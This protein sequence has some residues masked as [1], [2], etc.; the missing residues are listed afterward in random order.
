MGAWQPM[1]S[2]VGSPLFAGS[3]AAARAVHLVWLRECDSTALLG[4]PAHRPAAAAAAGHTC[5]AACGAE[6]RKPAPVPP[7]VPGRRP[8][9]VA[10]GHTCTA[11]CILPPPN[12]S[13][14]PPSPVQQQ[15]YA[16]VPQRGE[17]DDVFG[18]R[19]VGKGVALGEPPH[20]RLQA[21][22]GHRLCRLRQAGG[23]G[24]AHKSSQTAAPAPARSRAFSTCTAC[25]N[26]QANNM[27]LHPQEDRSCN[28]LP[29]PVRLTDR[30]HQHPHN[31]AGNLAGATRKPIQEANTA[32][33]WHTP[34]SAS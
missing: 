22:A 11:A 28:C 6:L 18:A 32:P 30:P 25:A 31:P 23:G 26:A 16:P 3:W 29:K 17:G 34:L 12:H 14:I 4:S 24:S 7:H 10:S 8:T 33:T 27:G 9:T 5:A 19:Q 20:Q 15:Q 2:R 21:G 1:A 13:Q